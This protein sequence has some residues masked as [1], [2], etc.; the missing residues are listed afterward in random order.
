MKEGL[1]YGKII[2]FTE[3]IQRRNIRRHWVDS[4][5]NGKLRWGN[6]VKC[7]QLES[8]KK[9]LYR[10]SQESVSNNYVNFTQKI[11]SIVFLPVQHC[12]LALEDYF[13]LGCAA[14]LFSLLPIRCRAR[15]CK[16]IFETKPL[17][18]W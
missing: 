15:Y 13:L 1:A 5:A 2:N 3:R 14:V 6:I 9:N 11:S 17:L 12:S 8:V 4:S 16:I 18:C 10:N 7:R